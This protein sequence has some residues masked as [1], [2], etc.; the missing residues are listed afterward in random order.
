MDADLDM[1]VGG[2][3]EQVVVVD[4]QTPDGSTVSHAGALTLDDDLRVYGRVVRWLRLLHLLHF[5]LQHTPNN[6]YITRPS[7]K[8]VVLMLC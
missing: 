5:L 7:S 6:I 2:A 8:S 1:R 3:A 4:S